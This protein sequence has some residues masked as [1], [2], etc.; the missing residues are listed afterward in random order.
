MRPKAPLLLSLMVAALLASASA[1]PAVMGQDTSSAN[2][3]SGVWAVLFAA[4]SGCTPC[5]DAIAW[6]ADGREAFPE[7]GYAVSIPRSGEDAGSTIPDGIVLHNDSY[8]QVRSK[9]IVTEVPTLIVL[10]NGLAIR[11]L[12]WPF[13]RGGLLRALAETSL[14]ADRVPVHVDLLGMQVPEFSALDLKGNTVGSGDLQFPVVLGFLK[15]SCAS[16]PGSAPTICSIAEIVNTVLLL[17]DADDDALEQFAANPDLAS[18]SDLTTWIVEERSFVPAFGIT[19]SPTY[20]YIREER[21]EGVVHRVHSGYA[22]E[23]ELLELLE[24]AGY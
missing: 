17:S 13:T 24:S 3:I 9:Y 11:T 5:E 7:F 21:G 18:C 23:T 1:S 12:E 10:A 8:G 14:I 6:L 15:P 20:F 2:L 19:R 4:R 16:C 22:T